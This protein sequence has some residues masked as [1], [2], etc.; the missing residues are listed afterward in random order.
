MFAVGYVYEDMHGMFRMTNHLI[1]SDSN[2]LGSIELLDFNAIT[3]NDFYSFLE[4]YN[5]TDYLLI[6]DGKR[7]HRLVKFLNNNSKVRFYLFSTKLEVLSGQPPL[8]IKNLTEKFPYK[9]DPQAIYNQETSSIKNEL[10]LMLTGHYPLNIKDNQIKHLYVENNE[11]LICIDNSVLKNCMINAIIFYDK[12]TMD[13]SSELFPI[14]INFQKTK[15]IVESLSLIHRNNEEILEGI[16]SFQSSGEVSNHQISRGII[17]YTSVINIDRNNRLFF[18]ED[19]IYRDYSKKH[20]ITKKFDEEFYIMVNYLSYKNTKRTTPAMRVFPMVINI[21]SLLRKNHMY[22]VTP[23]NAFFSNNCL[24]KHKDFNLIGLVIDDEYY[25][26]DVFHNKNY[27]V[28]KVHLL[29]LEF[30][31]KESM[32]STELE[33]FIPNKLASFKEVFHEFIEEIT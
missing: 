19:G 15:K 4:F 31:L 6:C 21:S 23:Y 24:T 10:H 20:L 3:V 9:I 12:C 18:Y 1:G 30:Y 5:V 22:M 14:M 17:D 11:L 16:H 26:Y 7:M 25:V 13:I 32:D 29:L 27:R 28:N 33:E 8:C 2:E